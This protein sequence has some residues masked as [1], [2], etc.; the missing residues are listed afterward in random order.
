MEKV[1]QENLAF[2]NA[3]EQFIMAEKSWAE[4]K[5]AL[6]AKNEALE[7][8]KTSLEK[9]NKILEEKVVKVMTENADLLQGKASELG[10]ET[11]VGFGRFASP[12][13][14]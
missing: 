5:K 6:Q 4:E 13:P 12:T 1:Q 10:Q 9:R 7:K 2:L 8:E 3:N 14:R 11:Q